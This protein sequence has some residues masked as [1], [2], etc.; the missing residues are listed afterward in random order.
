MKSSCIA[1]P[2]NEPLVVIRLWQL[3][4]C[5]GNTA[6]AALLSFFEYWHNIKLEMSSKNKKLIKVANDNGEEIEL[7]IS[8]YQWHTS[9][10]LAVGI[11]SVVNGKAALKRALDI[12][13]KTGAI[14][15]HRNPNP[16]FKFDRTRYFL[17]H[18]EV[19]IQ[20]INDHRKYE[21]VPREKEI[22]P[23]GYDLDPTITEITTEITS[24]SEYTPAK[25]G[26]SP[27]A[28]PLT[29]IVKFAKQ[30]VSERTAP[31]QSAKYMEYTDTFLKLWQNKTGRYPNQDEK[32]AITQL[33]DDLGGDPTQWELALTECNLHYTGHRLPVARAI[34]VCSAGGTWAEWCKEQDEKDKPKQKEREPLRD[35]R[36]GEIIP[37][38]WYE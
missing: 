14:S 34:E 36:T 12:L 23:P 7:D 3:Q 35:P 32:E 8:L 2:A 11:M 37:N 21:I 15:I 22:D 33:A 17:F 38:A 18:P 20:Y 28:E 13:V 16:R 31:N 30:G 27:T 10:D 1:H 9:N 6:A 29:D 19:C 5:G 25:N 26:N 24:E 4:F